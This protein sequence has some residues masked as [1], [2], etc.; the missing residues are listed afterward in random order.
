[1]R[2]HTGNSITTRKRGI[3]PGLIFHSDQGCHY[4]SKEFRAALV[5]HGI[6]QS[7]SRR[8]N[9]LDNAVA[10]RFFRILKTARVRQT[11]YASRAIAQHDI[12]NYIEIFYNRI[13]RHSANGN[14]SPMA[15]EEKLTKA[16]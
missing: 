2:C 3:T 7:M 5:F 15:Y 11:F 14:I 13:W 10:E 1:M 4:T 12:G 6:K 9:C 8:G 16:A